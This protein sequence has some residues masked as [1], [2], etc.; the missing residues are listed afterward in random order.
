MN[1]SYGGVTVSAASA[2]AIN[3]AAT[4]TM[5]ADNITL[6]TNTQ[7]MLASGSSIQIESPS[8][9]ISLL[10]Q[11]AG[12]SN[13]R[14]AVTA[15]DA[16]LRASDGNVDIYTAGL[17]GTAIQGNHVNFDAPYLN[18]AT[19]SGTAD[20]D[21]SA[22]Y[23]IYLAARDIDVEAS[24]HSS[25][26]ALTMEALGGTAT[27]NSQG[28]FSA[29]G[30]SVVK[31]KSISP[32]TGLDVS[33]TSGSILMNTSESVTAQGAHIVVE[34]IFHDLIVSSVSMQFSGNSRF[35]LSSFDSTV[36]ISSNDEI[37]AGS[38]LGSLDV[39]SNGSLHV[40]AMSADLTVSANDN[41]TVA[42]LSN[43]DVAGE[44]VNI[45]SDCGEQFAHGNTVAVSGLLL[46]LLQVNKQASQWVS[47]VNCTPQ[48]DHK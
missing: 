35:Q 38:N 36:S 28:N 21:I 30:Q 2:V 43:I 23:T 16:Q 5:K 31:L 6:Q 10:A 39:E 18:I 42:A 34:S 19:V 46:P 15:G 41:V 22:D 17:G 20:V 8:S 9:P 26:L 44:S 3:G 48:L 37:L 25:A 24:Q 11:A 1:N 7:H 13:N 12:G 27:V 47:L 45:S 4:M 32:G 40:S 14:I 33:A 29:T